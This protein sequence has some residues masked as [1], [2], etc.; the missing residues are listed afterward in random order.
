MAQK[1]VPK[2]EY[3]QAI[4][5]GRTEPELTVANTKYW[6]D[7]LRVVY[8]PTSMLTIPGWEYDP[9]AYP[10][11]RGVGSQT[12]RSFDSYSAG[13]EQWDAVN[14]DDEY[15]ETHFRPVL[16]QCDA[17][18]GVNVA[19]DVDSGWGAFASRALEQLRDDYVPKS[20]V[21]SW[22]LH[23][24]QGKLSRAQTLTRLQSTRQLV[25]HSS[26][27]LPMS[28]PF[29]RPGE[30]PFGLDA[31][32]EWHVGALYNLVFESVGILS[33]LRGSQRGTMAAIADALSCGTQRNIVSDI[34]CAVGDSG[35]V[36]YSSVMASGGQQNVF[37]KAG[38][39]RPARHPASSAPQQPG[40]IDTAGK[41]PWDLVRAASGSPQSAPSDPYDDR[42]NA[43]DLL[44]RGTDEAALTRFQC[45]QPVNTPTSFP[46]GIVSPSDTVF[47]SLAVTTAPRKYLRDLSSAA[48]L[49]PPEDRE[50]TR[51]AFAAASEEYVWG[52]ETD[53]DSD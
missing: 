43:A 40:L 16:E 18:Q 27:Y 46:R 22:G 7:Y 8:H 50:D 2:H 13:V 37:S 11:G 35:L 39:L 49:L 19:V 24:A 4:D 15:L 6:T 48:F 42:F 14:A 36:S 51:D 1:P 12:D 21:F 30:L 23:E 28:L 10:R 5:E 20:T 44:A 38:S 47:N 29:V 32:S 31:R 9:V 53:S 26:L 17:L 52:F 41:N 33:S 3:Q 34:A 25:E 45:P